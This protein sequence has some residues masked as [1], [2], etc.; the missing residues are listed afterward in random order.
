MRRLPYLLLLLSFAAAAACGGGS[1]SGG[2]DTPIDTCTAGEVG[3]GCLDNGTCDA[4]L[5]C[6]NELCESCPEGTD[7]CACAG[8]TSCDGTLTCQNGFCVAVGGCTEGTLDCACGAVN[9]CAAGLTCSSGYCRTCTSDVV[10]CPCD[11]EGCTAGLLCGADELC[12]EPWT[13]A[14]LPVTCGVGQACVEGPPGGDA[15][16][17]LSC[18]PCND[19]ANG[20]DGPYPVPTADGICIC[21]TLPGYFYSS[22]MATGYF[23]CDKDGDGWVRDTAQW[24]LNSADPVIKENARCDLRRVGQ[25]VLR[26]EDGQTRTLATPLADGKGLPLYETVRNDDQAF[27]DTW[28]PQSDVPVYGAGRRLLPQ[29]VN[30]FTK[31][32]AGANADFNHNGVRDVE[33]WGAPSATV[34]SSQAAPATYP[35]GMREYFEYYTR[36][37][38]FLELYRGWYA[39]NPDGAL[40]PGTYHFAEKRRPIVYGDNFPLRY[41]LEE[42]SGQ[43]TSDYWQSCD[44][45]RDLW[46]EAGKPT[47]GMDFASLSGPDSTWRGLKHHS[48]FKCV[49]VVSDNDYAN[50][51]DRSFA[52]HKQ[53]IATLGAYPGASLTLLP[54]RDFLNATPNA[55][56]ALTETR[57]AGPDPLVRNPKEPVISCGATS[58]AAV[59]VGQ[60][61]WVAV[62]INTDA[63]KYD[64][65][66]IFQCAG[67][68]RICPGSDPAS[69]EAQQCFYMCAD[70]AASGGGELTSPGTGGY[71]LRG[72]VPVAPLADGELTGGDD[73]TIRQEPLP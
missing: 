65:G 63:T 3:C 8:G 53:A 55:C 19:A 11:V 2:S 58:R 69:P 39:P 31:A 36:F 64:R 29:E 62:R 30:G 49:Q 73:Y 67:F 22:G 7:G 71:R 72:E 52:R 5:A 18:P 48:Q 41:G 56:T 27:M 32:C 47:I 38:Y 50:I 43:W 57:A 61:L 60:V 68:P 24:A 23:P 26:N 33:E 25:V 14:T 10:G 1:S 34:A 4:G 45:G 42:S 17:Q 35:T 12:R 66:C 21:R 54:R 51:T 20:E 15:S 13:C 59:A 9:A 46:Y 6:V 37:S 16:C 40:L 28:N 44:R 70:T